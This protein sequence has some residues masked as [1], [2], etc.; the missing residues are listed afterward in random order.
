MEQTSI[1]TPYESASLAELVRIREALERLSPVPEP[2]P[3]PEPD[4]EADP[5]GQD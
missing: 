4:S 3:E 2:E 5:E 1:W